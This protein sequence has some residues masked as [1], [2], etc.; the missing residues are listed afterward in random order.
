LAIAV[1]ALAA[2]ALPATSSASAQKVF[3]GSTAPFAHGAAARPARGRMDVSVALRWR[4]EH[5]LNSLDRAVSDPSSASYGNYLSTEEFRSRFSPT[6]ARVATVRR[7]LRSQ[8]LQVGRVSASRMLIDASGSTQAVE[9]AFHTHLARYSV[10]GKLRR[11]ASRPASMPSK[12]ARGVRGI[13]GL[14]EVTYHHFSHASAPPPPAFVNAGPCSHYW[15]EVFSSNAVPHAYGR[16]QPFAPC[17]YDA[18][19]LQSAYGVDTALE[20]GFTGSGQTVGIVDAFAAPTIVTDVNEY[21][22]RHGLPPASISQTILPG[23]CQY[24][25]H[26]A[27]GWYGEE[28]LDLEAVHSMAPGANIAYYG[29]VDNSSKALLDALSTAVD[30][31]VD[32]VTN[33]YGSLGE[34]DTT[35]AIRAQEDVA[36]EAIAQGTGLYFSS[37]DN[38]DEHT[39][40]GYVSADYPS[41]SPRV[42]SVGGTSLGVG[43]TGKRS[44]ETGW[45]TKKTVLVG[46]PG[47]PNA[48]WAPAPPGPFLYGSGGGTSRLFREPG[49]QDHVVPLKLSTKYGSR[50]RVQPD[51]SMDGDPTTG[52]L[53]GE[54]QTFPNGKVRYGEYRIG[55]TSL[56]SPLLAGYIADAS[57]LAGN[58]LGFIN[59]ALYDLARGDSPAIRDVRS[60]RTQIAALRNDFNN[61]VNSNDGTTISLRSMNF[62]TSLHT[63]PGYDNVT[64]L[65]VPGSR[66]SLMEALAGHPFQAP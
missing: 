48:H 26:G 40:L 21:S 38:G 12:V 63:E 20:D 64:G 28:T 23:N 59:P 47:S 17:G 3:K 62:D 31:N 66:G 30:D 7:Y 42:T 65:G 32:E 36:R 58:R 18:Q 37:G 61:G 52:M 25:C 9:R 57:Q 5:E 2:A 27:Q 43:P 39:Y 35:A 51:L 44:F 13:L 60:P 4:N 34:Q 11:G 14:N 46:K 41:S 15:G 56:S 53:V 22:S 8:G 45:G 54:T 29:A 49:Y 19:D 50:N 16:A 24:G 55:G 6:A 33:S 1:A 10:D